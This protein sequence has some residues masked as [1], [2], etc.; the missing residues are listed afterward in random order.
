MLRRLPFILL[1]LFGCDRSGQSAPRS[2][3]A[4][5][6]PPGVTASAT[7]TASAPATTEPSASAAP[8]EGGA[9]RGAP[10][11]EEPEEDWQNAILHCDGR[12]AC[13]K[14]LARMGKTEPHIAA[15]ARARANGA[16]S[17]CMAEALMADANDNADELCR[18]AAKYAVSA[19]DRRL[20]LA[21]PALAAA[22]WRAYDRKLKGH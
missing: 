6:Q 2:S 5:E 16:D 3:I 15:N 4:P 12:E 22:A 17:G 9:G 7:A 14:A 13:A 19:S 21:T 8:P 11:A 1:A 10:P 18:D 20:I